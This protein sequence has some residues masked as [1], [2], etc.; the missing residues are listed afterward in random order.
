MVMIGKPWSWSIALTA[1]STVMQI[2]PTRAIRALE[3]LNVMVYQGSRLPDLLSMWLGSLVGLGGMS[4]MLHGHK[5]RLVIVSSRIL[6]VNGHG[7]GASLF[8]CLLDRFQVLVSW[9]T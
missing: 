6:Q 3:G 2:K 1:M 9:F 5:L 7:G 4:P 8:C